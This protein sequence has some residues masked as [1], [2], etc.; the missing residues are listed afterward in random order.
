[1]FRGTNKPVQSKPLKSKRLLKCTQSINLSTN[2]LSVCTEIPSIQLAGRIRCQCSNKYRRWQI[3]VYWFTVLIIY[4]GYKI[5]K[6]KNPF[7]IENYVQWDIIRIK[8]PT[9]FKPLS[10]V[11]YQDSN[12]SLKIFLSN[13][14]GRQFSASSILQNKFSIL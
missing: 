14:R 7:S 4:Q 12:G 9:Q 8:S 3:T 10:Q 6:K 5:H 13:C 2:Q 1:M 11:S